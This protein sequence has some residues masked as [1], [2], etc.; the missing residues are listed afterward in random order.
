MSRERR[1]TI[2]SQVQGGDTRFRVWAP[3][4]KRVSV[5][6]ESGPAKGEHPLEGDREGFFQGL[7]PKASA[8]DRYRFRLGGGEATFSDPTSRFQPEGPQ[9]PSELVDPSSFRW[10]D[11]AWTGL[12]LPGQVLYEMHM[13][14]FTQ[15][16]T[17][18]AATR[19]LANLA[20]LGVTVIEVMP[21]SEFPGEFGWGYDGVNL[22]APS[23]LYG[24]PDDFRRFVDNAHGSGLGVILDVVYNHFGPEG[25]TLTQYA[26]AYFNDQR[27][28]EWGTPINFDGPDSGPVREYF[29]ENA[30]YWIEEFHLDGLRLDATQAIQDDSNENILKVLRERV[31]EAAN[32]RETIVIHENESQDSNM[33]RPV[34][35]GGFGL[36]GAWNDDFHHSAMVTLTGRN[37]A[38]Y[39]DHHGRPQEFIS[40]VKYGYLFQ[41][42]R[43]SW[44]E[45]RRGTIGFDLEPW[46][47]VNF[48]QNHDQVP[49][50]GRGL[51]CHLLT[52]P[53]RY[54]AMTALL[55][56][57]PGTPLLFQGQE[58][59]A[60]TP[61]IYF[62]DH[63]PELAK[64]VKE[65]R[66]E[67]LTQFRRLDHPGLADE[68]HD[69]AERVTFERCKLDFGERQTHAPIYQLHKDLLKLRKSDAAFRLQRQGG[70][71]GAVLGEQAFVLRFFAGGQADRLL[72][73]NFGRDLHLDQTPEPLLAPPPGSG[74]D[75]LFSSESLTYGGDGTPPVE[76]SDGWR[77]MG[78]AAV[79]LQPVPRA[80]PTR[81]AELMATRKKR[82]R[83]KLGE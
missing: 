29:L 60:S 70:V 33:I 23:H 2:R 83:T 3:R 26:T 6:M 31:R 34:E 13:G 14:T 59:A 65:G 22:F 49:N 16:G 32:G 74:W 4:H 82:E 67:F 47:F 76:T 44:Q 54:R 7:V 45:N 69:P 37:E 24:T 46:R 48:L 79:V 30:A 28:N 51:R 41:G 71:D 27:K 58:F 80:L 78:E 17:W 20:E 8:G 75:I 39:S 57:C 77:L 52:S 11:S 43:Y 53:G 9:G 64:L 1:L 40:N 66:A 81:T 10:S 36:D 56:L 25:N 50:S 19:E 61:F 42:Q 63:K 62:A 73:V 38:Y 21:V 35:R 15:E 12:S 72:I 55:L 68:V 18:A 5:V